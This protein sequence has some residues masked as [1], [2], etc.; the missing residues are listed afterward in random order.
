MGMVVAKY[1]VIVLGVTGQNFRKITLVGILF[2]H[3]SFTN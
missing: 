2:I 3:C 1:W